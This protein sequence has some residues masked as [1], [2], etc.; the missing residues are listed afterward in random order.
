M[1]DFRSS[2]YTRHTGSRVSTLRFHV[3]GALAVQSLIAVSARVMVIILDGLLFIL[4]AD[5]G[6]RLLPGDIFS[7]LGQIRP[8]YRYNPSYRYNFSGYCLV[9]QSIRKEV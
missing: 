2:H 9:A 3:A 8:L 1:P 4:S 7:R 5:T 6:G